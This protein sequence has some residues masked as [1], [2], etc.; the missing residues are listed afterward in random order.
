MTRAVLFYGSSGGLHALF[1]EA[2]LYSYAC[3]SNPELIELKDRRHAFEG[4]DPSSCRSAFSTDKYNT[5]V[6][7]QC[8]VA[9]SNKA[10][11]LSLALSS[12]TSQGKEERRGPSPRRPLPQ[13]SLPSFLPLGSSEW[14]RAEAPPIPIF[15]W[16]RA[17]GSVDGFTSL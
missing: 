3:P 12:F 15:Q 7:L 2:E 11:S 13:L 9:D 14:T 4:R 5:G 1:L 16:D 17:L 6:E 8:S 10:L